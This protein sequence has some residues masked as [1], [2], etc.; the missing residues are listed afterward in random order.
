LETSDVHCHS[1]HQKRRPLADGLISPGGELVEEILMAIYKPGRPRRPE[2]AFEESRL[3][4]A[5]DYTAPPSLSKDNR[6]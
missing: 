2:L 6:P 5:A 4:Q 1:L 3:A